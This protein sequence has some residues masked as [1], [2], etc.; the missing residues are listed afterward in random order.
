MLFVTYHGVILP[1]PP[2]QIKRRGQVVSWFPFE[3]VTGIVSA[4][5]Q[6]ELPIGDAHFI[7]PSHDSEC[8]K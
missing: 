7:V 5:I 6:N 8:T 4:H 1:P 2:S 3:S